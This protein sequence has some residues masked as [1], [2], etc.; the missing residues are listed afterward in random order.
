M[1]RVLW[2]S[3]FTDI[4]CFKLVRPHHIDVVD[5]DD[6]I[7]TLLVHNAKHLK[8]TSPE[9]YDALIECSAFVNWRHVS[10]GGQPVLAL[11]FHG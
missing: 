10:Q 8:M 9:I 4:F 1:Q 5:E 7:I 3:V 2:I 11:A 6:N